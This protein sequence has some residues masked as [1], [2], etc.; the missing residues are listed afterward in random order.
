MG[1]RGAVGFRALG[2]DFMQYNHYDSYPSGLGVDVETFLKTRL[3]SGIASYENLLASLKSRV[4]N[5]KVLDESIPPTAE[6]IKALE[7]W[8]DLGVSTGKTSDWYCLTRNM[9]GD[10][11]ETLESGYIK[12]DNKFIQNSLFCEWAYLINLDSGELEVYE[13][14]QRKYHRKGRYARRKV[15]GWKPEYPDQEYFYPCALVATIQL[16]E[17]A[18]GVAINWEQ[19]ECGE[20]LENCGHVE[21]YHEAKTQLISATP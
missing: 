4:E 9:Q 15:R 5:L 2:Q 1:T 7:P 19:I 12:L 3:G 13:G 11:A 14:F 17:I 21:G 8:T 16:S 18:Q 20:S 6:D 10:L